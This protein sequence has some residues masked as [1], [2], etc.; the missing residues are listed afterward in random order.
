M[1]ITILGGN[2]L[3]LIIDKSQTKAETISDMFNFMGIISHGTSAE[4]AV[5]ELSARHRAIIF[6]HPEETISTP[7]L[8]RIA[9]TYSLDASVFAICSESNAAYG[10]E[11]SSLFDAVFPDSALSSKTLLDIVAY[12]TDIGKEPL[13][14]Y[15]IAGIEASVQNPYTTYFDKPINLT[16]TETMI[17]RF[18]IA[19]YPVP[20]SARC[21]LK[22]AF[23]SGRIP[24]TSSIRTHISAINRKF[25]SIIGRGVISFTCGEGYHIDVS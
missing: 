15:R 12:V 19:S 24:E 23:K 11:L 9:K 13:G 4:G 25:K 14:S 1:Q 7:D 3:L 6:I 16:K 10:S 20:Q 8:V 21:V 2:V 17:L 5:S 22:Y 18:L